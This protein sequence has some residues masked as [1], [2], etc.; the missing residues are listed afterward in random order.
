MLAA[1]SSGNRTST[2]ATLRM[3]LTFAMIR[4]VRKDGCRA[5]QL[6]GEH[7]AD[8]QVR[9][10]GGPE[11]QE[12]IGRATLLFL[13]PVCGTDQEPRLSLPGVTPGLQRPGKL[14]R[15]QRP[16]PLVESDGHAVTGKRRDLAT[17]VRQFG[18]LRRPLDSL[19]IAFDQLGLRRAA[20]LPAGNDVEEHLLC[21][22]R[23]S[24][25]QVKTVRKPS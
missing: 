17:F 4:M 6:L 12:Q 22:E 23:R 18:Q 3:A 7:R 24:N 8:E 20:D 11:R 15:R 9:P 10:G 25:G 13:M 14:G 21:C 16:A 19:Q 2:G 1:A 5:E